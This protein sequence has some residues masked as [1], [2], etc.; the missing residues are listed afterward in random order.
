MS[1]AS[2]FGRWNNFVIAVI[3]PP[4]PLTERNRLRDIV[5][6]RDRMHA[7]AVNFALGFFGWPL[8]GKYEQVL[9]IEASGVSFMF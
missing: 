6:K 3:S 8:D 1:N 2:P 5:C 9:M 4:Q 7:S